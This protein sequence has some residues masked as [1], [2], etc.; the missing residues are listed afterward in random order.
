M[1]S[2]KKLFRLLNI[3]SRLLKGE[4]LYK[5]Q[6]RIEFDASSKSIERDIKEIE[7]LSIDVV[8]RQ[9]MIDGRSERTYDLSEQQQIGG[10]LSAEQYTSL[11]LAGKFLSSIAPEMQ[12]RLNEV[13]A[14][15]K[16]IPMQSEEM[17]S[18]DPRW[19]LFGSSDKIA[20]N[21]KTISRA[22]KSRNEIKVVYGEKNRFLQVHGMFLYGY[23]FY[24]R[25]YETKSKKIKTFRLERFSEITQ[26]NSTYQ[27]PD[28]LDLQKELN[29]SVGMFLD[30]QP[31]KVKV[32]VA[33][34]VAH[35]FKE[36]KYWP[37]QVIESESENGLIVTY[38][39]NQ[40]FEFIN[41]IKAWLPHLKVLEPQ[42]IKDA[43]ADIVRKSYERFC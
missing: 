28:N 2:E 6:L 31:I 18:F 43:M 5:E 21:M 17:I 36:R 39:V 33:K 1:A 3:L 15:T 32:E 37:S 29:D 20:T 7:N 16:S 13:L 4:T 35:Y 42:T 38:D 14:K 19:L 23:N 30:S 41:F 10:L 34:E 24:V 26:L 22:L 12:T 8:R 25:A 40:E 27:L 11:V 9:V